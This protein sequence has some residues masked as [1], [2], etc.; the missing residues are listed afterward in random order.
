MPVLHR[1]AA[2]V[3]VGVLALGVALVSAPLA[4]AARAPQPPNVEYTFAKV[5]ANGNVHSVGIWPYRMH[6]TGHWRTA[7]GADGKRHA[8][9][10]KARSMGAIAH[11]DQLQPRRRQFAAALTV[12][13]NRFVGPKPPNLLQQGFFRDRMMWK[14]EA[15]PTTGHVR[16]RFK[17]SLA[18]RTI[19]SRIRIDDHKFHTVACFRTQSRIGVRVDNVTRWH[20]ARVGRIVNPS[21]VRMGNKS[22]HDATQQFRGVV[23]YVAVAIG[24]KAPRRVLAD[25][26]SIT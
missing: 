25:A 6:L 24:R 14:V 10:L 26:P 23:D 2:A 4:S 3:G 11:S 8:V 15:M 12:R 9:Q 19:Q 21:Q 17:G 7:R 1:I 18:T 16:C 22:M 5:H 20:R 13:L